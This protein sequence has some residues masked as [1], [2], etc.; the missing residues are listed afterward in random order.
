MWASSIV[1]MIQSRRVGSCRGLILA[2]ASIQD[3]RPGVSLVESGVSTWQLHANDMKWCL[4]DTNDPVFGIR[5]PSPRAHHFDQRQTRCGMLLTK[6][7][8]L[9]NRQLKT[10]ASESARNA[11]QAAANRK[12]PSFNR[13]SSKSTRL[14]THLGRPTRTRHPESSAL[15]GAWPHT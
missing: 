3:L 12:P 9:S 11:I 8:Y 10:S 15:S 7:L 1:R 6:S 13:K 14:R 4:L 2:I 5:Q